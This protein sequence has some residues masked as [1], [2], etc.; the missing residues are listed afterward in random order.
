MWTVDV[1]VVWSLLGFLE[2]KAGQLVFGHSFSVPTKANDISLN[3]AEQMVCI[4]ERIPFVAP[5]SGEDEN[6]K[7]LNSSPVAWHS[8]GYCMD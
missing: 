3:T 6:D 8:L 1:P 4:F 5:G 7:D 2:N